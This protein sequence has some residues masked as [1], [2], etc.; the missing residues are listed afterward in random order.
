MTQLQIDVPEEILLAEKTDADGLP[1]DEAPASRAGAGSAGAAEQGPGGGW[2]LR[3]RGRNS[4]FVKLELHGSGSRSWSFAIRNGCPKV[5]ER[6]LSKAIQA[7]DQAFE[8]LVV[9][10]L[11][12]RVAQGDACL[13]LLR[14]EWHLAVPVFGDMPCLPMDSIVMPLQIGAAACKSIRAQI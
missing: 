13:G 1:G 4:V 12:E 2:G 9:D 3:A 10:K 5:P 8:R 6:P 7:L 11:L 14:W